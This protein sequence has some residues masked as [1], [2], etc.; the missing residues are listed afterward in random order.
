[1]SLFFLKSSLVIFGLQDEQKKQVRLSSLSN[2]LRARLDVLAQAFLFFLPF[3]CVFLI[4][5]VGLDNNGDA[6]VSLPISTLR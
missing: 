4:H 1:M 6:N 2:T 3:L 5:A